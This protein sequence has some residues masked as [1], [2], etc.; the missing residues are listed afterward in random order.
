MKMKVESERPIDF[1]QLMEDLKIN[2]PFML[3]SVPLPMSSPKRTSLS[4]YLDAKSSETKEIEMF[5]NVGK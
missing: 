2:L 5:F 4:I 1:Y 3:T